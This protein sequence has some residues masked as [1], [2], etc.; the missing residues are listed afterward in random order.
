MQPTISYLICTT[1]RSGSNLLCEALAET[2]VAGK[3][4][5]F[6]WR[7]FQPAWSKEWAVSDPS[8]YLHKAIDH[9]STANGVFGA[10]LMIYGGYIEDVVDV[11]QR[12]PEHK[13]ADVSVAELFARA[14]PNLHYV[15][16]TRRNKLRQAVSHV[17]ATQTGVWVKD[18]QPG[19]SLTKGPEFDFD[20]LDRAVQE[21]VMQEAAWQE[22][23]SGAGISPLVV[24]YEDFVISI[25]ETVKS[26]LQFLGVS[27]PSEL[28]LSG[29][30]MPEALETGR[31]LD[32][33]SVHG[34]VLV[35]EQA[36]SVCCHNDF[37]E[38]C[39]THMVLQKAL[40]VL[41]EGGGIETGLD[42]VHVQEPAEEQMIV[43]FLTEGRSLRTE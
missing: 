33:R 39:L 24:V 35:R 32:Q 14:F 7:D 1:P 6:F 30:K 43:Q 38:Q 31:R 16:L 18:K 12:L 3:P 27:T 8:D 29:M 22:L 19:D 36:V 34:E 13:G 41:G 10:K 9:G 11:I 2:G 28:N 25:R 21:T 15:W 20:A 4:G 26:I 17:R 40:T 5:E 42:Q 23:M 37:I